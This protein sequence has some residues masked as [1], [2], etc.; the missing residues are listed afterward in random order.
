MIAS[1]QTVAANP[2]P[3][4]AWGLFIALLTFV[5]MMPLFLGLFFILPLFGHG[6]WHLYRLIVEEGMREEAEELDEAGEPT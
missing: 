1:F 5:A 2:G 4:L 6:T 3:M